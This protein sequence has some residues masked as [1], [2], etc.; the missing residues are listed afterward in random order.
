MRIWQR[1][2][3]HG[4]DDA[5][6]AGVRAD[7]E[8]ER[9]D[10]DG[11]E[12]GLAAQHAHAEREILAQSLH[13]RDAARRFVGN[14]RQRTA[15]RDAFPSKQRGEAHG[16]PPEPDARN[17]AAAPPAH[18]F[19]FFGEIAG[20]RFAQVAWQQVEN[21]ASFVSKPRHSATSARRLS[22]SASIARGRSS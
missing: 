22:R 17:R 18:R 21:H 1:P 13:E 3:E 20:D 6:D 7:A 10:G 4:V 5:E 16:V 8:R 19:V 14:R 2:P 12:A 15:A 9:H 11:G